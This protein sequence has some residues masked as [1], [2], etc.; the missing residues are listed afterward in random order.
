ML[1]AQAF[2]LGGPLSAGRVIAAW[3]VCLTLFLPHLVFSASA[4]D[5]FFF[6][7]VGFAKPFDYRHLFAVR[8]CACFASRA[9]LIANPP[10]LGLLFA[11]TAHGFAVLRPRNGLVVVVVGVVSG[12]FRSIGTIFVVSFLVVV[13]VV[14]GPALVPVR[15]EK[16]GGGMEFHIMRKG[17]GGGGDMKKKQQH[18]E[19]FV[20]DRRARG[21]CHGKGERGESG[22]GD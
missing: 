4:H 3:A 9:V 10:H 16:G 11:K 5:A 18:G 15:A 1:L 2:Y 13:V 20:W 8:F 14:R 21:D 6:P 7:A 19:R 22:I 17:K 12:F